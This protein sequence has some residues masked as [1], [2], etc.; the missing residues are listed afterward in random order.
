MFPIGF[1]TGALARGDF[2][3]GLALQQ[4]L[5]GLDAVELSALR[6]TELEPL[7]AAANTLELSKYQYVSVH[8]PSRLATLNEEQAFELLLRLPSTWTI[9]AHPEILITPALW[10][11]LGSRLCIENMDNRKTAGRNVGELRALFN[12]YTEASFCLDVGHARQIDPTMAVALTMAYEFAP[13]LRQ[14]HV[15]DVDSSGTHRQLGTL[16]RWAYELISSQIPPT[17]PLIIESVIPVESMLTELVAVQ[18]AFGR[19]SR[20]ECRESQQSLS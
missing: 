14:L 2:R 18:K 12:T 20:A 8:A 6:D 15:S 5:Q 16:A 10:R 1:S 11:R 17:C 9:V 3:R 7:V 13:R 19:V 4:R